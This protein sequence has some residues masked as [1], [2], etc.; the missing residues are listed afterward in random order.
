[1]NIIIL[2][3]S[4]HYRTCD[5]SSIWFQ[6]SLLIVVTRV[7]KGYAMALHGK[8]QDSW[9]REGHRWSFVAFFF[10]LSANNIF[11]HQWVSQTYWYASGLMFFYTSNGLGLDLGLSIIGWQ[12]PLCIGVPMQEYTQPKILHGPN[13][14]QAKTFWTWDFN[15]TREQKWNSPHMACMP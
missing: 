11:A 13:P 8:R 5:I 3:F 7:T 6:R 4:T 9:G 1:M 12:L 14:W 15:L 2:F 10:F